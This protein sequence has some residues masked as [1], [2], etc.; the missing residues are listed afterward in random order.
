MSNR[1]Y[2]RLQKIHIL[3]LSELLFHRLTH[4]NYQILMK[5]YSLQLYQLLSSHVHHEH[6]L[7]NFLQQSVFRQLIFV[8]YNHNRQYEYFEK[9]QYLNRRQYWYCRLHEQNCYTYYHEYHSFL[10]FLNQRFH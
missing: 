6:E 8:H 9:N 10:T 5:F 7:L 3:L 4:L 1:R 2:N